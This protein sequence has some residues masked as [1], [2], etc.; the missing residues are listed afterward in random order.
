[1]IIVHGACQCN[2][3]PIYWQ[4]LILGV[5]VVC[6]GLPDNCP[7][8]NNMLA[9]TLSESSRNIMITACIIQLYSPL[10]PAS[11]LKLVPEEHEVSFMPQNVLKN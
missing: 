5:D 11:I 1:M 6:L 3:H 10:L 2:I 8:G 4:G 9:S 7:G